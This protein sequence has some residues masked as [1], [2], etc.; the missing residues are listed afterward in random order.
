M[1]LVDSNVIVDLRTEDPTWR[2]WSEAALRDAPDRDE[3]AINP[4]IYAF[5]SGLV[6]MSDLDHHIGANT[7]RRLTLPYEAG[8]IAGRAFVE[9]RRR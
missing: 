6:T 5:A 7:F 4:I 1:I 9:Y 8:F 2:P 3:V